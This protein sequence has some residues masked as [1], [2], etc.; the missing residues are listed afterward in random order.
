MSAS[1]QFGDPQYWRT[2]QELFRESALATRT[3]LA[4]IQHPSFGEGDTGFGDFM[5]DLE[6]NDLLTQLDLSS[7][8]THTFQILAGS[9]QVV[10]HGSTALVSAL[11]GTLV[12][13]CF[14]VLSFGLSVVLF[15]SCLFYLLKTKDGVLSGL[16]LAL[17]FDERIRRKVIMALS[18]AI[19]GV[20][21]SAFKVGLYHASLT[22][23][24]FRVTGIPFAYL[25]C[26]I[27]GILAV[28]PFAPSFIIG[29]I[30]VFFLFSLFLF[31]PLPSSHL[32]FQPL[33][34]GH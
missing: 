25:G 11:I 19:S 9:G 24:S 5:M 32:F 3:V 28:M 26:L 13:G 34:L 7:L 33:I 6:V 31:F 23:I 12:M 16:T 20:F 10:W 4:E 1:L 8:V 30:A 14:S 15:V 29:A 27:S 17:P 21:V 18:H 22:W 2:L